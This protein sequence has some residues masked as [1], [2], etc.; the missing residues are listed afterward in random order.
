M[1]KAI[2]AFDGKLMTPSRWDQFQG[3]K[4]ALTPE[5]QAGQDV[6]GGGC[7]TCHAARCWRLVLP[8]DRAGQAVP[9]VE[10]PGRPS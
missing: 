8:E 9:A 5:E 6:R 2:G 3:D 1:A 7:K 4:A 10:D